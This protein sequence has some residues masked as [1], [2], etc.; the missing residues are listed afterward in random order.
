MV[1]KSNKAH[2]L[3]DRWLR[4]CSRISKCLEWAYGVAEMFGLQAEGKHMGK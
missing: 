2:C 3:G 4:L 1:R